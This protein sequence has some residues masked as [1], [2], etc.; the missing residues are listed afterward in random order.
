MSSPNN[1]PYP[2]LFPCQG[3][4]YCRGKRDGGCG[5]RT[6]AVL[7][8]AAGAPADAAASATTDITATVD[9]PVLVRVILRVELLT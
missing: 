3:V 1:A 7:P 2:L 6:G 9:I 5:A 4:L 8:A